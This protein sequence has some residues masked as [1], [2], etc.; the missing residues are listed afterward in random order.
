MKD[1]TIAKINWVRDAALA[2]YPKFWD[3]PFAERALLIAAILCDTKRIREVGRNRGEWVEAFQDA[4]GAKPG[5]S[6]CAC[7][8]TFVCKAA[9]K[10]FEAMGAN[11]PQYPARVVAWR[12][13]AERLGRFSQSAARTKLF[14]WDNGST[15][16]IGFVVG[17]VGPFVR[18]I[19]GN[20]S[21][22]ESGSQRDGD[23]MY[24][25][26]R[27]ASKIGGYIDLA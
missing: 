12:Q 22:G 6:W 3:F 9:R 25:R 20:T 2:R 16:H 24:R 5:D 4:A 18:T 19:E 7:M 1:N 27:L 8:V 21:S 17:K 26:V 14:C 11:L 15:G 23:G 10:P 13:Y